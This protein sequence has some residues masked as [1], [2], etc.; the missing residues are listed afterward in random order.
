MGKSSAS[1][2]PCGRVPEHDLQPPTRQ[3]DRKRRSDRCRLHLAPGWPGIPPKHSGAA[4]GPASMLGSYTPHR[5]GPALT[6]GTTPAKS[7]RAF[8]RDLLLSTTLV[9]DRISSSRLRDLR[10]LSQ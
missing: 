2:E 8:L 3:L 4:A 7:T 10:K 1:A 5:P 6:T 9:W